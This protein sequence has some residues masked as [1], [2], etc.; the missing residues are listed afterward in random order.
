[1]LLMEF[2]WFKAI[3]KLF[4][5]NTKGCLGPQVPEKIR[6]IN[7][8]YSNKRRENLEKHKSQI[9]SILQSSSA[10]K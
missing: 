1:M 2:W 10:Q 7:Y 5:T 9:K 8:L 4:A 6:V 3:K